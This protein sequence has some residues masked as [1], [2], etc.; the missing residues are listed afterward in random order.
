MLIDLTYYAIFFIIIQMVFR[1]IIIAINRGAKK[2]L[3]PADAING[4]KLLLRILC[5]FIIFIAFI[6]LIQ[7]PEGVIVSISSIS[8]III[9]FASTE[10]MSQV[11]SGIYLITAKPFGVYDLVK[12]DATVGI[13]QEIGMNYTILQKFDGTIVKIPNKKILDSKITNYT[14]K[15]TQELEKRQINVK[16]SEKLAVVTPEDAKKGDV[17]WDKAKEVLGDL[18]DFILENEITRYTFEIEIDLGIQPSEVIEKINGVCKNFTSVYD[19]T[20]LFYIM[21]LGYRAKFHFQIFCTNPH[22][23]LLNQDNFLK[24]IAEVLYEGGA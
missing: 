13:V 8:G 20:P 23:I 2:H 7:I 17:D 18:S 24:D 14:I 5:W 19:Y 4:I 22:V 12:I 6:A 15:M 9:G 21:D 3:F 1:I 10:I 11:I 16:A